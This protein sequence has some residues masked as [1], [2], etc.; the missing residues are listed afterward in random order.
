[1][2]DFIDRGVEKV[3]ESVYLNIPEYVDRQYTWYRDYISMYRV[4]KIKSADLLERTKRKLGGWWEEWK[5]FDR[6]YIWH[7][8]GLQVPPRVE[9][10]KTTDYAQQSSDEIRQVLFG[11][12][13]FDRDIDRLYLRSNMHMQRLMK[14]SRDT[15]V[16]LV[17]REESNT[18]Y[19]SEIIE[20]HKAI[21]GTF[22]AAKS[23]LDRAKKIEKVGTAGLTVL[24]T[25]TIMS[26]LLAKSGV[27]IAAKSGGFW[28]G[29]TTGLAVCAPSGPWALVCGAAVGTVTWVGVDFVVSKADEA[30]SREAFE[31][32][33]IEGISKMEDDFRKAMKAVYIQGIHQTYETLEIK[34]HTSPIDVITQS[35]AE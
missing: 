15:L 16:E 21:E 33:L 1:M 28:A 4:A 9:Y 35:T 30:I 27:K 7:E 10:V 24:M 3:F 13:R 19:S 8:K 2:N 22:L 17:K 31:N 11:D 34:I 20:I 23:D 6:K 29:A 12:G 25:K 14:N 18:S 26:K 5:Y 32:G